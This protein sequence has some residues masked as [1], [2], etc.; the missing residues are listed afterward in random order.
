MT[1]SK[2][3]DRAAKPAAKPAKSAAKPAKPAAKSAKPAKAT[4]PKPKPAT[5]PQPV[6]EVKPP[7]E[8]PAPR[9]QLLP[10]LFKA[11]KASYKPVPANV[12][13]PLLEQVLYACC[14]ENARP[15]AA[16]KALARMLAQS[17]DLNEVRVTTV[18]ELAE[19]LHDLPDPARAA[20]SLRRALQS[21]FE[22]T[23]SFSLEHA[24]KHSLAHG[25]KTLENLHGV[26]PFV[27]QYVASTALGGHMIPLDHGALAGLYLTGLVT[28]QE[29]DSGKVPGLERLIPKK[30]GVEFSSLL[31]QFGV[32]C[33]ANLHGATVKKVVQAVN[34]AAG[35]DRFPKRGEP[36][37]APNPPP[38]APGREATRAAEAARAAAEEHRPAG[39]QAASRPAGKTPLPPPGSGPKRAGDKSATGKPGPKPFVVK[40]NVGK[41]LTIKPQTTPSAPEKPPAKPPAPVVKKPEE[42]KKPPAKPAAKPSAQLAK[43]KPR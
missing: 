35:K 6:A 10:R 39:P 26:P 8:K 22:S 41:P 11:L 14:L 36:L 3:N 30:S 16:E 29:Y 38:P 32:D 18:A 4:P 25:L 13:R 31:H 40:P 15:E 28:K 37:P 7:V 5:A 9:A 21:V 20:L 2:R 43:R 17:F 23:Y 19:V 1:A 12:S 34:P 24:K 27:V 33:L 42:P